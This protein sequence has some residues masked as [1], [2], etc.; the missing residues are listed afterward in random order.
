MIENRA[1]SAFIRI[2]LAVIFPLLGL[3][4]AGDARGA[5]SPARP[6]V[7]VVLVDDAGYGDY[8]FHGNPVMKTPNVD[9]LAR[10][11]IRFTDFHVSPMCTP[12]RSQ[13]ITG[14]DCLRN[15][16]SAVWTSRMLLRP[17]IPTAADIF[18]AN[19]YRTGQFGK[20]HLGDNYP[21]RPQDRG[22]Q[23]VLYFHL[24]NIG[25]ADDYWC[26]DY[27]DP[28][29]RRGDGKPV[30]FQGYSNDIL[31]NEAMKWMGESQG[32]RPF[33][34]YLPLNLV[35][36]PLLVP[37]R[38]RDMY[39]GQ[40]PDVA[41]FFGM[42]ASVDENMGRLDAFLRQ[43][44]LAENTIVI[45]L[46]D[47]GGT[48]GVPVWNAGMRGKKTE[49]Y[50]G[51]H[52]SPCFVRW[53][54]G[55]L[56]PAGDVPGLTE[57][58]DLVPTLVEL[59]GLKD[60]RG[61]AFD[62]ISLADVLRGKTAEPPDRTLVVAFGFP[63]KPAAKG[64]GAVMWRRWRL[65]DNKELYDLATD[66]G[67]KK[68]IIAEHPEIAAR[69]RATYDQWWQ[70]VQP[71]F[72]RHSAIVVGDEHENPTTLTLASHFE[73]AVPFP[74]SVRRAASPNDAW[75]LDVARPGDYEIVLRRW[76]EEAHTAIVAGVPAWKSRDEGSGFSL[77]AG[78]ALP[79]RK[80]KLNVGDFAGENRVDTKDEGVAFQVSLKPGKTTLKGSFVDAA[81]KQRC[82]A[83]YV[84]LRRK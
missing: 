11:S 4:L 31:F 40:E 24:A 1:Q 37:Q 83:Y 64:Q 73:H 25:M 30:Q 36:N 57:V 38:Y 15:G 70:G 6:N 44:H 84:T 69:L 19:G 74:W 59:C 17:D 3:V 62:G 53:P 18:A 61:A 46:N 52:R 8:S 12:T 32:N 56:R 75:L 54:A 14:V 39:K 81:G 29:L 23:D 55:K 48:V 26:N 7:I 71:A 67:Q 47:N 5:D 20:W 9:R 51:G 78:P 68:N 28:W 42:V 33:F 34:C 10:E 49:Y 80:A 22:F 43:T 77:P 21:F 63:D 65:V 60:T 79:I 41:S 76:P 66:F 13:L 72:R 16:A 2:A 82:P 35:H 45:F 58:Q 50:E 27:F